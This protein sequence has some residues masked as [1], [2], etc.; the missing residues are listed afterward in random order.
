MVSESI[1]H[2]S[3]LHVNSNSTINFNEVE[4]FVPVSKGRKVVARRFDFF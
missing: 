2:I 1:K 4:Q 3:V